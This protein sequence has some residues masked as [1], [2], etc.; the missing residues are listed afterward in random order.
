MIVAVPS[1]IAVIF[2][3]LSTVATEGLL[4]VQVTFLF[5]ASAGDTVAVNFLVSSTAK[6]TEVSSNETPV[7]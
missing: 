7:T 2:P 1:A 5:V 3:S 4:E 6:V